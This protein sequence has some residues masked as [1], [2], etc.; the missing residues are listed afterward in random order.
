MQFAHHK[1]RFQ[2]KSDLLFDTRI[3]WSQNGALTFHNK[4]QH[5]D[6]QNPAH[7]MLLWKS[8]RS[9][10]DFLLEFFLRAT[11]VMWEKK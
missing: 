2:M 7:C 8:T 4:L 9:T 10:T 6:K 1:F 3:Q 11:L 5:M